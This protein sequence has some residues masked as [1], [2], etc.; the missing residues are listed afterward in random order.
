MSGL[1][2]YSKTK[3]PYCYTIGVEPNTCPSMYMS[4]K[5][6]NLFKYDC[7]DTFVDGATVCV[8]GINTFNICRRY[9]NNV[10]VSDVGK[11]LKQ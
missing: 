10:L 7:K 6:D 2:M 3:N 8:P 11:I 5:N 4:I 9:L 1:S